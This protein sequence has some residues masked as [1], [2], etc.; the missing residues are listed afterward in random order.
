ME[1]PAREPV[2][3]AGRPR[4]AASIRWDIVRIDQCSTSTAPDSYALRKIGFG[5]YV[6]KLLPE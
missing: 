1:D 5:L 3:M 4:A 2:T 6:G